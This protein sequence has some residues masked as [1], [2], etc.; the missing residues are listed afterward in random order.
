[1]ATTRGA[2]GKS[3]CATVGGAPTPR[4]GG[5]DHEAAV[6]A[7]QLVVSES[8]KPGQWRFRAAQASVGRSLPSVDAA[9]W[10]FASA[11]YGTAAVRE[12]DDAAVPMAKKR[13]PI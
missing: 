11:G 7:C 12:S 13:L 6:P 5:G 4:A 10:T 9:P 2:A 8:T 3:A 1:M